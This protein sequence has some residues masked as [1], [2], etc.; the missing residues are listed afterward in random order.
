[1]SGSTLQLLDRIMHAI[2]VSVIAD[3]RLLLRRVA[4]SCQRSEG[5]LAAREA[6][7]LP[8]SLVVQ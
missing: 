2:T 1:M 5:K 4:M 7:V 3:N 6:P 8:K